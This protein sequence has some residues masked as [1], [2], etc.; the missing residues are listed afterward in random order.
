MEETVKSI[1][2]TVSSILSAWLVI[3]KKIIKVFAGLTRDSKKNRI[4]R[5]T[6]EVKIVVDRQCYFR[7]NDKKEK[8]TAKKSF[9]YEFID[10]YESNIND[11]DI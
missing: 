10:Y 9:T 3:D 7:I 5:K 1:K 8:I 4:Y 6:F 2:L 11:D